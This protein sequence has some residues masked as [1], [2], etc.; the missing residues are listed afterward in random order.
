M[1]IHVVQ[2]AETLENVEYYTTARAAHNAARRLGRGGLN[3]YLV[4]KI[5]VKAGDGLQ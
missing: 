2:N 4:V 3:N 1:T 5:V